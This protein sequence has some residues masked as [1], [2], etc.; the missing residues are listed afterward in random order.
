MTLLDLNASL[1][2]MDG[3][4]GLALQ[5]PFVEIEA[6]K[7]NEV[8]VEGLL[9]ERALDAAKKTLRATSIDDGVKVRVKNVYPQHIGLGSGTQIALAVARAICELYGVKM[10]AWE[11]ARIVG[12]GGTSGIGVAAFDGGGFILDGGHSIKY[13][14]DFLPSSASKAPPPPL[15]ARHDFP[16]W[17]VVLVRPKMANAI[18]GGREVGIF[19]K[20][21]PIPLNEVRELCHV[22]L[23]KV[24]PSVVEGNIEGFGEGIRLIQKVGF[25]KIEVGLQSAEVKRLMVKC[26]KYA[27][28]VGLSSFG[29]TIYCITE[30]E[31]KLSKA[32]NPEE[33]DVILTRANNRGATVRREK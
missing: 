21:C 14:K 26:G 32:L 15:L 12:R 9:R 28:A 3:G 10:S 4:I 33:V 7:S 6:E 27:P 11:M 20:Y 18:H 30:D 19:Q 1:G 29:P 23:M 8:S 17:K 16:D 24:L 22:V 25:K 31:S 2:R 13:K 5:E